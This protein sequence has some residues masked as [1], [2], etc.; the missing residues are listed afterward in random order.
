MTNITNLPYPTLDGKI[1]V[2]PVW[3]F[4]NNQVIGTVVAI[5]DNQPHPLQLSLWD[6]VIYLKGD[7]IE[8]E[9]NG[10]EVIAITEGELIAW[11][12]SYK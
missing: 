10:K 4:A 2:L 8:I 3:P 9:I 7:G 5:G 1:A 12:K 6:N 11:V